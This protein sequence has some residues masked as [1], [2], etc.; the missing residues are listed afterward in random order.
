MGL[1][2]IM[3]PK[4]TNGSDSFATVETA[5]VSS[6][7]STTLAARAAVR[8]QQRRRVSFDTIVHVRNH[9]H[10]A[11]PTPNEHR[12]AWFHQSEYRAI[13]K[14]NS[15]IICRIGKRNKMKQKNNSRKTKKKIGGRNINNR[16]YYSF[17][18]R[19]N[20]M[21]NDLHDWFQQQECHLHDVD[22]ENEYHV[23]EEGGRGYSIRG[24]ENE[25]STEKK[26]RDAIYFEATFTV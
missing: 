12:A 2:Y 25:T 17:R 4:A 3:D 9:V 7:T 14:E 24:L 22:I 10:V 13:L 8:L 21:R 19:K 1:L 11:E 15:K 5:D 16:L 6:C 26:R 20:K 23:E 18:L